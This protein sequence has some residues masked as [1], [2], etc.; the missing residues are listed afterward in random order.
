MGVP[1]RRPVLI[2]G[3]DRIAQLS[4]YWTQAGILSNSQ[5][6]L[7]PPKKRV[8]SSLQ[9][10]LSFLSQLYGP[11][12]SDHAYMDSFPAPSKPNLEELYNNLGPGPGKSSQCQE[13]PYNGYSPGCSQP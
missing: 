13:F 1:G 11:E 9:Q 4:W 3:K 6:N 2:V 12:D 7:K 8:T 5:P 10:T